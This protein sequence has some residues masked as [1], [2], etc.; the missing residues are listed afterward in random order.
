MQRCVTNSCSYHQ[1]VLLWYWSWISFPSSRYHRPSHHKQRFVMTALF[2]H[3]PVSDLNIWALHTMD[4]Y[5]PNQLLWLSIYSA[6]IHTL[7]GTFAIQ[8]I[9]GGNITNQV[10]LLWTHS[11]LMLARNWI[12][13]VFTMSEW[14]NRRIIA[15]IPLL[16]NDTHTYY[17]YVFSISITHPIACEPLKIRI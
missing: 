4:R 6:M 9:L 17:I 5:I 16:N 7:I 3:D 13:N 14:H 8:Y 12:V 1:S 2:Q 10:L 15:K 11:T